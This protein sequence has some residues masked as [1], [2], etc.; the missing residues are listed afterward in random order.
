[1]DG[2]GSTVNLT[3][4][5]GSVTMSYEYDAFGAVTKEEDGV[6]WKK[7]DY[8]FVGKYGVQ[9]DP[10]AGLYYMFHRYYEPNLGRFITPDPVGHRQGLNLYVYVRNNPLTYI[11][12]RGLS[13]EECTQIS[14]WIRY[15][16]IETPDNRGR[17]ISTHE[18]KEW[19]RTAMWS[20]LPAK[21]WCGCRWELAGYIQ[22][23]KYEKEIVES[24]KFRCTEDCPPRIYQKTKFRTRTINYEIKEPIPSIFHPTT[25]TTIGVYDGSGECT[26]KP[27]KE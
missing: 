16:T 25:A 23:S 6:G 12:P 20:L 11:D 26:C 10:A 15:P 5:Y 13:P 24:A 3:N 27:P 22:V 18:E 8:K 7:N 19:R 4:E 17:L 9:D 1:Y 2:L 14:E 21:V